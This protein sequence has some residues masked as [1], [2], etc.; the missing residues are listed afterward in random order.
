VNERV[1]SALDGASRRL[2]RRVCD[3]VVVH[4]LFKPG[5]KVLLML[6]GG[7][8][9]MTLLSL[10][11]LVS[12][13]L[14]LRLTLGAAHVDYGL[15]GADSDRDRGIVE[16]ACAAA[17]VEFHALRPP[18]QS[19]PNFQERARELRYRFALELAAERGYDAIVTAHNRDD[20]AETVLYRLTKYAA[21]GALVGMRP[22][23]GSVVRPLLCL[24]AAEIRAYCRRRGIAFGEDVTNAEPRYARN[25]IRLQVIP[26]LARLNPRVAETLAAGADLAAD[27]RAVLDVVA[28]EAWSRVTWVATAE[29]SGGEPSTGRGMSVPATDAGMPAIDVVALAQEPAAVRSLVVRRLLHAALG[30]QALIERR[31]VNAVVQLAGGT[32]GSARVSLGGGW[33]AVREYRRLSVR[34]RAE[35]HRCEAVALELTAAPGAAVTFCGRTYRVEL[36]EGAVFTLDAREA[37]VGCERAPRLVVFRHPRRGERFTPLGLHEPVTLAQFL[38]AA[39]VPRAARGATVVVECDDVTVWVAFAA[40]S[41]TSARL[42]RVAEPARVTESSVCTVHIR[43]EGA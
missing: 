23:E 31:I 34:R 36:L 43:E 12:A 13:R 1:S 35:R 6:S 22:H 38:S 28:E 16:Q 17:G 10:A 30:P 42:G 11:P 14:D 26:A 40:G 29:A 5:Q 4:E 8:D 24:G 3:H 32:A 37:F 18:R 19:G 25:A 27:E 21:P 15:R 7:A 33:E 39:R 2:L 41:G 9:S 20:Q